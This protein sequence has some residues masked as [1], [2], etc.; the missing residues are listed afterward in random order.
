MK[1]TNGIIV[2]IGVAIGIILMA[3]PVLYLYNECVVCFQKKTFLAKYEFE[4]F[5]QFKNVSIFIRGVDSERNPIIFVDAPHVVGDSSKVECYAVILDKKKRHTIKAKWI[6]E[7]DDE[8]DT[9]KLQQLAHSFIQYGIP[10]LNV[11]ER[12]N[13]FIYL[14]D[15]ETLALVRFINENE[16]QKHYRDEK[17][18]NVK[19]NWYKPK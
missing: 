14:K 18:I 12:G 16:S 3:R 19:H 1:K 9:L 8:A 4:D 7:Y 13:V 15:V 6:T 11:D 10:R 2:C 17:W 5:S